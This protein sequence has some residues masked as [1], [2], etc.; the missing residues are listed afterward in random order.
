MVSRA[1]KAHSRT[2]ISLPGS[3]L[4]GAFAPKGVATADGQVMTEGVSYGFRLAA[5]AESHIIRLGG[6]STSECPGT[7]NLPEALA[8]HLCV[9]ASTEQNL[10]ASNAIVIDNPAGSSGLRYGFVVQLNSDCPTAAACIFGAR[11]TWAVTSP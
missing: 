2:A 6:A 7:A 1:R 5:S 10:L 9:Y 11:G 3:T 8:G 4:R